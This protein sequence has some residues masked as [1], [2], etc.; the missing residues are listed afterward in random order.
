[1]P[2]RSAIS[3]PG[4]AGLLLEQHSGLLGGGTGAAELGPLLFRLAGDPHPPATE[5]RLELDLGRGAGAGVIRPQPPGLA[6]LAGDPAVQ[7]EPDGVQQRG[8][9]RA[10]LTVQQE[11]P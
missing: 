10:R 2:I 4:S 6:A 11:Q 5:R 1:M 9:A 8:L 3:A 7:G